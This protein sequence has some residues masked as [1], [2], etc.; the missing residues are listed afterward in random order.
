[1]LRASPS[2]IVGDTVKRRGR[3]RLPCAPSGVAKAS[4]CLHRGCLGRGRRC[5]RPSTF[6]HSRLA[7]SSRPLR[8]EGRDAQR[9]RSA[10]AL[11]GSSQAR[12]GLRGHKLVRPGARRTAPERPRAVFMAHGVGGLS[13][14]GIQCPLQDCVHALGLAQL[15]QVASTTRSA[16]A[17]HLARCSCPSMRSIL[18]ARC[19]SKR[20]SASTSTWF[21]RMH[22][23]SRSP[24]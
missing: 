10:Q 4:G 13:G 16:C 20:R 5:S 18:R 3:T 1:M 14:A 21:Q 19:A 6:A 23:G 11:S 12:L 22:N 15:A 9:D 8:P 24:A 2:L 17:L 7:D